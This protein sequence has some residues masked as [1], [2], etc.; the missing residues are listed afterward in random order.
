[1]GLGPFPDVTLAQARQKARETRELISNGVDPIAE[2]DAARQALIASQR[3]RLTF[4][5]AG[6]RKH[7]AI[8][9]EFRNVKHAKQWLSTLERYAVPVLGDMDVATIEL[10]HVLAVLEPIWR[11]KTE[12]ASR[13]RQRMEAVFSWAIVSGHRTAANPAEWKGNLSEVLPAPA[14]I[15]KVR[16][17]PALPWQ[18]MPAFMVELRKRGGTA[19]PALAFAILTAARSGEVR[20]A[21]WDEFDIEAALW[22]VPAERTKPRKQHRVPLSADALAIIAALPRFEGVDY[23][24]AS[25]RG[26]AMSD[27]ALSKVTERMGVDA[28][29][30]GFRS[31]FKD[32]ARNRTRAA[33]EVSELALAHVNSDATRAAYA[34][35]ELLPQRRR[36]M[37]QW[38][39][40]LRP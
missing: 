32:W 29:P 16:H 22:T 30:H 33:D 4:A 23:V 34:R 35:D 3:K 14:K 11:T 37:N 5:Q 31:S 1:M 28:V 9:G 36:M 10:P 24:F 38:A 13:V 25:A 40:F 8:A 18:E 12:T 20:W 2:R 21:T 15:T 6:K 39:K 26:G 17:H 7:S 19:A 27:M